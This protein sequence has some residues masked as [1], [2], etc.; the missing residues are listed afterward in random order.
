MWDSHSKAGNYPSSPYRT[1]LNTSPRRYSSSP[2]H[3]SATTLPPAT[4][5]SQRITSTSLEDRPQQFYQH[6]PVSPLP[7]NSSAVVVVGFPATHVKQI[8]DRFSQYGHL[9]SA[10]VK[11]NTIII[12]Y[13]ERNAAARAIRED[14]RWIYVSNQTFL[15]GVKYLDYVDPY[16]ER[17]MI[18]NFMRPT[19]VFRKRSA[20]KFLGVKDQSF[21]S[22]FYT[23][24]TSGW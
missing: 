3:R 23:F 12:D 10:I 7:S 14:G 21:L 6:D 16:P 5:F 11:G 4:L 20:D 13:L 9:Q 2:V 24:M 8:K 19:S 17:S 18:S 1:S 15:I 22:R